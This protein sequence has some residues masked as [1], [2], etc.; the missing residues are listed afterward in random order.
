MGGADGKKVGWG[1]VTAPESDSSALF[2][3]SLLPCLLIPFLTLSPPPPPPP[4]A[5]SHMLSLAL[6]SHSQT[7]ESAAPG[8]HLHLS[9]FSFAPLPSCCTLS[10]STYCHSAAETLL[11]KTKIPRLCIRGKTQEKEKPAGE[12]DWGSLTELRS[13]CSSLAF[14]D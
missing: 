13:L 12:I 3:L 7:R 6:S 5:L 2:C 11:G 1:T 10:T 4:R 14:D 9:C 8:S